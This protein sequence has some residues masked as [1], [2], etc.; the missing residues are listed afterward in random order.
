MNVIV[1]RTQCKV[2]HTISGLARSGLASD[3]VINRHNQQSVAAL[4]LFRSRLILCLSD[5]RIAV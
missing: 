4:H 2:R 5:I 1:G 3:G